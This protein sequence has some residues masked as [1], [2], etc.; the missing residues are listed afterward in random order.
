MGLFDILKKK[1]VIKGQTKN[2][3]EMPHIEKSTRSEITVTHG[4]KENI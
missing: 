2:T 3:I 1:N 4:R